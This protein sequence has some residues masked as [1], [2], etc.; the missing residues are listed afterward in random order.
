MRELKTIKELMFGT[1]D[2][3]ISDG[4]GDALVLHVDYKNGTYNLSNLSNSRQGDTV[5]PSNPEFRKEVSK[6]A[7]DLLKRKHGVNFAKRIR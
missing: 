3:H 5:S 7:D 1:A 6:L 2:Y 4:N